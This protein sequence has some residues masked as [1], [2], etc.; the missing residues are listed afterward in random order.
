MNVN[1]FCC[2]GVVIFFGLVG[3]EFF[4]GYFSNLAAWLGPGSTVTLIGVFVT[5]FGGG[6]LV[7]KAISEQQTRYTFFTERKQKYIFEL[8]DKM[9]WA[10]AKAEYLD[11]ALRREPNYSKYEEKDV[12]KILDELPMIDS[13]KDKTLEEW[14]ENPEKGDKKI[15]EFFR[16]MEEEEAEK[17]KREFTII[18][19]QSRLIF[20]MEMYELLQKLDFEFSCFIVFHKNFKEYQ[21]DLRRNIELIEENRKKINDC[22]QSVEEKHGEIIDLLNKELFK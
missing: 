20:G 4:S 21:K 10:K 8:Y 2:Y 19:Q 14:K 1:K 9:W 7:R 13:L 16:Q 12:K 15:R 5:V 22:R 17:A 3:F 18:I 6:Y 11:L